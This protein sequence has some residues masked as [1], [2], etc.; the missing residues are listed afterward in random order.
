MLDVHPL[1]REWLHDVL[2]P[3]VLIEGVIKADSAVSVGLAAIALGG[4]DG[5]WRNGAPL[6]EWELVPLKARTVLVCFDSDVTRKASV[7]GALHRLAGYLQR[8]G[9]EVEIV[10]LPPGPHGP[11]VGLDDFLAA[12]R[13][14]PHPIGLL[15]EHAVAADADPGRRRGNRAPS[16]RPT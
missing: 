14:S 3:L 13:G 7:R 16:Y 6:P 1:A 9:A 2:V 11:K 4:V 15:L 5:G 8:R 12:R 10:L